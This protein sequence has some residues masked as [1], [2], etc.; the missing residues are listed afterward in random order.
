MPFYLWTREAVAKLI[1]RKFGL[2]VSLSTSGRYLKR[3]GFTPQK[4][5]RRALE[6][7]SQEVSNWLEVEYPAIQQQ[8]QSEKAPLFQNFLRALAARSA[9]LLNLAEL[10]RDLGVALNTAKAWLTVLEATFQVIILRPYFA[11]VGKRLVKSP[12]VYFSDVGILCHLAGLRDPEHAATGPM[13]GAIFK[14]GVLMEIIKTIVHRGQEP[15]VYF[16]RT[17]AGAEVDIVVAAG[18]RLIPLEVK[19]YATPRPAMAR[20]LTAFQKDLQD[21]SAPGYVIHPGEVRLPLAPEVKAL[22]F[23]DL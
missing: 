6:Q 20:H 21:H 7:N 16:W 23:G 5:V 15:Q 4:P 22:P 19:L 2:R 8:A 13:G 10:A 1:Q 14:T 3:W 17:A 12:K 11:N 18:G 9:Q